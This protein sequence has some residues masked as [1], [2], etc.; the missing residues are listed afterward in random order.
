MRREKRITL[1]KLIQDGKEV[2]V[3]NMTGVANHLPKSGPVVFQIG[4]ESA[5]SVVIP[6][7][8]DPVCIT[9][10]VDPK[11]LE[12]CRDLFK[13]IYRGALDL[14]DPEYAEEYYAKNV[15]RKKKIEEKINKFISRAR[16]KGPEEKK[17]RSDAT[18]E[19]NPKVAP[20]CVKAKHKSIDAEDMLEELL[21]I[22]HTLKDED[23]AYIASNGSYDSVK[24]WAKECLETGFDDGIDPVEEAIAEKEEE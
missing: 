7:G 1:Q 18:T 6:A 11:S 17:V 19:L 9:D 5:D 10:Q 24:E 15:E 16:D 14:L 2:W 4:P 8:R 12:G 21:E 20:L 23:F 13:L 3:K 22:G